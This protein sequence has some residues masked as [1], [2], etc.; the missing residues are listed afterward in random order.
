M[1]NDQNILHS[2]IV[3]LCAVWFVYIIYHCQYRIREKIIKIDCFFCA[4]RIT[5]GFSR[6]KKITEFSK[7]FNEIS[8][9]IIFGILLILIFIFLKSRILIFPMM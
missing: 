6:R 9:D 1:G 8:K 3:L 4:R 2:I 7:S 5:M